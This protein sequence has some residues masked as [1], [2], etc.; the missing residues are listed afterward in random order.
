[1]DQ[2]N[3]E[4]EKIERET[5]LFYR[6]YYDV[7]KALPEDKKLPY[8]MNILS[9]FFEETPLGDTGD[10]LIDIA[11]LS[12]KKVVEA[13]EKNFWNGKKG[14]APKGNKN[15]VKENNSKTT[16]NNQNKGQNNLKQP[17]TTKTTP[18][19]LENNG[20]QP[21]VVLQNNGKQ[22]NEKGERRNDKGENNNEKVKMRN[23]D[24]CFSSSSFEPFYDE[25]K[26]KNYSGRL[27]KEEAEK[28]SLDELY[29][30][31]RDVL[32]DGKYSVN[33][34]VNGFQDIKGYVFQY[35]L[36]GSWGRNLKQLFKEAMYEEYGK[37]AQL[38]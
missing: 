20:E 12:I 2:I 29:E 17:K 38:K 32:I 7:A 10:P 6:T 14:G 33:E 24:G 26:Q 27:S 13:N 9:F 21:V 15:A 31:D 35:E 36:P 16:E 19:V 22:P 5:C 37:D 11:L 1:M 34:Y 18:L 30:M 8:I 4:E 25:D 3:L 28:I 23:G